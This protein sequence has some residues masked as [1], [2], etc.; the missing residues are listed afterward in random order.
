MPVK[1][2]TSNVTPYY[3]ENIILE[4]QTFT[5]ELKWNIRESSWYMSVFTDENEEL[6]NG[7]KVVANWPL[8]RRLVDSKTPLGQIVAYDTSNL[9]LDPDFDELGTRVILL[10]YTAA[11]VEEFVNG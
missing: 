5:L 2:P 10:Y 3:S 1:I 6:A 9:G 11:E 7:V 4:G 8:L